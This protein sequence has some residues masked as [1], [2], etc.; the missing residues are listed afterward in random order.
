M[1]KTLQDKLKNWRKQHAD[2]YAKTLLDKP[3][4]VTIKQFI[5][6]MGVILIMGDLGMGKSAFA[7]CI[8]EVI[9]ETQSRPVVLHLPAWVPGKL[10]NKVQS[11]LPKWVKVVSD[12]KQWPNGAVVIY[13]EAA[14]SAHARRTQA[15]GAIELDSLLSIARQQN[16]LIIFISHHSRKLDPNIVQQVTQIHWKQ[17]T[18]AHQLFEREEMQDFSMRA[19]DFFQELREGKPWRLCSPSVVKRVK[20][21]TLALDMQDFC[22]ATLHNAP[23]TYWSEQLSCAF[24]DIANL[25]TDAVVERGVPGLRD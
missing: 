8:A 23:A 19:F 21:T 18:F 16:Q 22:F 11:Y 5:P 24:K 17:P 3:K 15:K 25:D 7:H 1:T 10:K 9:H 20:S 6:K 14:L 4:S 13:D 2:T 12:K